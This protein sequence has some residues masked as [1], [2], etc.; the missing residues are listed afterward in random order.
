MWNSDNVIRAFSAEHATKITGMSDRTLAYWDKTGFFKPQFATIGDGRSQVR[1]YSFRDLISLRTLRVLRDR[2]KVS[3]Q[4]LRTVLDKLSAYSDAPFAELTL[5]VQAK[6]VHFDEP[7]TGRTR[8]V[9][10]GQYVLLPI[11]DVINDVNA[12]AD[13]I[14]RRAEGDFGKTEQ[15]RNINHN[16]RVI[17]G[18]RVPVRA[19]RRFIEAGYSNGRIEE[20]YPSITDAD[21]EAIRAEIAPVRAA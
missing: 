2:H 18:T 7:E 13:Q 14:T 21:I 11:I 12:A 4:H 9:V 10:S 8:G 6:E 5:R 16:V 15:H 17:S 19:I 3:L 20:E 1:V